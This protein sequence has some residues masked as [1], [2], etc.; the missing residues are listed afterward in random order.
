MGASCGCFK[1]TK[2]DEITI[3]P[4]DPFLEDRGTAFPQRQNYEREFLEAMN[5]LPI[6]SPLVRVSSSFLILLIGK[7]E[8]DGA[9]PVRD[10][11]EPA[12]AHGHQPGH[13]RK[14]RDLLRSLVLLFAP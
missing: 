12:A 13:R 4:K 2:E 8:R 9:L 11:D 3:Q 6:S 14:R 1:H 5:A 10:Q 7:A